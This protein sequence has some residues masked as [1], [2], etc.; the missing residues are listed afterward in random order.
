MMER[1]ILPRLGAVCG[2]L[3]V[4][5]ILVGNSL[6]ESG[7]ET[8]GLAMELAGMILFV[9]FLGYLFSVLRA[10]EGEDGWLS[11]TA[12]GAGLMGITIKFASIAPVL[13]VNNMEEGTQ[14]YRSLELMNGASFNLSMFPYAVLAV[15]VFTLTLRTRVLPVWI[16]WMG[17]VTAPALL[18]NAM[19]FLAENIMAFLLF[20]LWV[21]LLSAVLTWRAGRINVETSVGPEPARVR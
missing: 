21:I 14:L 8:T 19:F 5:L 20:M 13:A 18:V 1:R 7:N 9:P 3:Y 16:G 2:I 17:A 15:A 12:F 6:Y 10:A 11:A 4:V